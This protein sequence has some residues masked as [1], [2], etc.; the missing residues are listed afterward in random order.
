MLEISSNE[1]TG[2]FEFEKHLAQPDFYFSDVEFGQRTII[3]GV[4]LGGIANDLSVNIEGVENVDIVP[5][6]VLGFKRECYRQRRFSSQS[7]SNT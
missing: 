6:S 3:K 7:S 4:N 5:G 1:S 2:Q